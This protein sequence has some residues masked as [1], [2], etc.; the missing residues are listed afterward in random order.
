MGRICRIRKGVHVKAEEAVSIYNGEDRSKIIHSLSTAWRVMGRSG[1]SLPYICACSLAIVLRRNGNDTSEL[2]DADAY[3][4][5][6]EIAK[7]V[8]DI[9]G[10]SKYW[11]YCGWANQWVAKPNGTHHSLA[12]RI[13]DPDDFL[14]IPKIITDQKHIASKNPASDYLDV[15][16]RSF[17]Y[18]GEWLSNNKPGHYISS[19]NNFVGWTDAVAWF[20]DE[21]SAKFEEVISGK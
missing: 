1:P 7:S 20:D 13:W 16:F 5:V 4:A 14:S 15:L 21:L 10:K 19:S 2:S 9:I 17:S 18:E 11:S 12:G 8:C 6:R 3:K